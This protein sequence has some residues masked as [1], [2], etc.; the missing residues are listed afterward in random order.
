[1]KKFLIRCVDRDR[2][3]LT[4]EPLPMQVA[5]AQALKLEGRGKGVR[6]EVVPAFERS[7]K[8]RR[9][10]EIKAD[11]K[12]RGRCET[13]RRA[14]L[15]SIE[16]FNTRCGQQDASGYIDAEAVEVQ[17]PRSPRLAGRPVTTPR[18]V[19]RTGKE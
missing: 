12:R 10:D 16:R 9:A 11:R 19:G 14:V 7:G 8:L 15:K 3:T 18:L 17:P 1:M 5:E 4:A 13:A 2:T 6:C